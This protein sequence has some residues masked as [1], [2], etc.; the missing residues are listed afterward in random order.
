M[1]ISTALLPVAAASGWIAAKR[2]VVKAEIKSAARELRSDYFR[3][4]NYLLNEQP[5]EAIEVFIRVLEVDSETVETHLALGNLYRRRG[6]VDR[7]IR[8]HQNLIARTTLSAD[9]RSE[10]LLE[11]GQDYMSA[12]LLDRAES[13]YK[14]L[15]EIQAYTTQALRQ[16]IDIYEQEKD[17]DKALSSVESL[18]RVTGEWCGQLIAHYYCE[19]ASL[20]RAKGD[21]KGAL[22]HTRAALRAD[23]NCV[24]ASLI[25]GDVQLH[26]G[27]AKSALSSY[28]RVENQDPAYLGEIVERVGQCVNNEQECAE[29]ADYLST[30]ID[31]FNVGNA[32]LALSSII[33][34]TAGSDAAIDFL[35]ARL[36]KVPSTAGLDR[37]LALELSGNGGN[38]DSR[39]TSIKE[40]T[41]KLLV[42]EPDY[43][44]EHC[45]FTARSL[46][47]KCPACKYWNTAKPS[48]GIN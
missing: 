12:G 4:I 25:E 42:R 26:L 40:V 18:E 28:K 7:A 33:E 2:S 37:L 43:R 36:G 9:E 21:I 11:L 16:V 5:D 24:R 45:G 27:D 23:V 1:V 39:T 10:A 8:I 13:L 32:V 6:E 41:R 20:A 30:L 14:E 15:I 34:D 35:I 44:C 48:E 29:Y 19:K 22:D 3:G 46:Y 47:W 17:W 38:N 31:R